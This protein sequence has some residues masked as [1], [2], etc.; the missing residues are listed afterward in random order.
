MVGPVAN[1]NPCAGCFAFAV[2]HAIEAL[3]AIL[4]GRS[5]RGGSGVR[6]SEMQAILCDPDAPGRCSGGWVGQVYRYATKTGLVSRDWWNSV[7]G[8]PYVEQQTC[9]TTQLEKQA[10]LLA[11]SSTPQAS[12]QRGGRIAGWETVTVSE[13][14]MVKAV[15]NQPVVALVHASPD[16]SSY[17]GSA[18]TSPED[19]VVYDGDCSSDS[20]AANHAV[21]I[22][23]YTD[24]YWIV[25]NSWGPEWGYG[26][27]MLLRRGVNK[28]GLANMV[29]YPVVDS[30]SS[31]RRGE[32][33][34]QG[35]CRAVGKVELRDPGAGAG[36]SGAVNS[37]TTLRGLATQ[38][39]VALDEM[40]RVNSHIQAGPDDP[41]EPFLNYFVPPCTRDV[42]PQ[43][44]PRASC[45]TT[46]QV[47]AASAPV[48]ASG[49]GAAAAS[50]S[51]RR[52][53]ASAAAGSSG[54]GG[55]WHDGVSSD[56]EY[57]SF[58]LNGFELPGG[59]AAQQQHLAVR[60][61]AEEE[62]A[63]VRMV[64]RRLARSGARRRAAMEARG[65]EA[66]ELERPAAAAVAVEQEQ[67]GGGMRSLLADSA[68]PPEEGAAPPTAMDGVQDGNGG[69]R[70][71]QVALQT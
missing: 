43:P 62:A 57:G 33:L 36:P 58:V 45:G 28:C 56:E 60:R 55:G 66:Y 69:G 44:V 70:S 15:S 37:T 7:Q 24:S 42:P 67:Q 19:Q 16:W 41:L 17:G 11:S 52:M 35:F 32:L 46:Y 38:Y 14:A 23:G 8:S 6:L 31:D 47:N 64:R 39:G 34:R 10:A 12:R 61:A 50:N 49:G 53:M 3:F 68:P 21:L 22:V 4:D 27:Y 29:T 20:D 9:P 18:S 26:G 48:N 40:I 71:A 1:Q 2:S 51:S 30:V 5:A 59:S 54:G 65:W 13:D 63:Q 25:K